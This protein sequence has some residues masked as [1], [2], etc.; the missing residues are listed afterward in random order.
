MGSLVANNGIIEIIVSIET[1]KS[2]LSKLKFVIIRAPIKGA[3]IAV[4]CG[5]KL[6]KPT[7]IPYLPFS[8]FITKSALKGIQ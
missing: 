4:K 8:E 6:S 1:I 7:S 5:I 2:K 3:I